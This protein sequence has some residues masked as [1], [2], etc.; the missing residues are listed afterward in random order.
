MTRIVVVEANFIRRQALQQLLLDLGADVVAVDSAAEAARRSAPTSGLVLIELQ[1]AL[2]QRAL[3][4]LHRQRDLRLVLVSW[5]HAAPPAAVR[6]EGALGFIDLSGEEDHVRSALQ[7]VAHG[8]I[9]G[10][11]RNDDAPSARLRGRVFEHSFRT[12]RAALDLLIAP[13]LRKPASRR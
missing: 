11:P 5:H 6:S 13:Y 3:E 12:S 10:W 8:Q 1:L 9:P 2:E 7:R 4:L